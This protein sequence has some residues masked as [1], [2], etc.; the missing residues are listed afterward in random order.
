MREAV[1]IV[2]GGFICV[3]MGSQFLLSNVRG[4]RCDADNVSNVIRLLGFF[5]FLDPI[6]IYRYDGPQ[7]RGMLRLYWLSIMIQQV[8]LLA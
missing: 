6:P 7:N 3:G 2:A 1:F 4:K 5:F 8:R